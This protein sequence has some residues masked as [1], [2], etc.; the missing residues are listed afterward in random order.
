MNGRNRCAVILLLGTLITAFFGCTPGWKTLR[1]K[2]PS[3]DGLITQLLAGQN[4]FLDSIMK[5]SDSLNVQIIYTE[6]KR[7]P[8]G[9]PHFT[10]HVLHLNDSNYFYPASTVKFPIVLLTLQR[11][12]ELNIPGLDMNT[13]MIT[14][15]ASEGQT[16][17]YN[18]PNSP[19]GRPTIGH[20]IKRILLVSDN[21]A[22]NRLYEFLGPDYINAQLL[23]MGYTSAQII[24]R[25]DVSLSETQNRLS[26]PIRFVDSVGGIIYEL[27]QRKS[28]MT[29]AKRNTRLGRGFIRRD[30]LINEPFDFSRKNR[31]SLQD[32]HRMM[33]TLI[34][35]GTAPLSRQFRL[36]ESDYAF[37]RKYLSMLPRESAYPYYDSLSYP[38]DY[39]KMFQVRK[40]GDASTDIR[41]FS[42][43][44]WAYGFLTDAA[45]IID[46]KNKLEYFLSAT[47]YCNSDGIFNDDHYDFEQVGY[48]FLLQLAQLIHDH[49]SKKVRTIVPDLSGFD[50]DYRR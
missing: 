28:N 48:P 38:D 31:L 25:L 35:P 39:A 10:E 8:A 50:I 2:A 17:I 24:H 43:A 22:F 49:E 11:L 33:E 23:Q 4:S 16:A 13:T 20:Y 5:R 40:P 1:G 34:F 30:S 29:H 6:I 45:Y 27:P 15:T 32:L 3:D 21:D 12:H 42:K 14:E 47:I 18:D 46:K 19:D 44:G 9:R 41:I 37:V 7:D 36:D 26:N